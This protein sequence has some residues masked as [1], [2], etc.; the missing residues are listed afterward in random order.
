LQESN[1]IIDK[2]RYLSLLRHIKISA[3]KA[4]ISSK[5][6]SAYSRGIETQIEIIDD[7]YELSMSTI[8][9]CRIIGILMDNAIEAVDLCDKKNVQIAIVKND[10][11]IIFIINN[12][13]LEDTPPV[14]K[15]YEENFSTKGNGRGIGLKTVRHIINEKYDNVILNT[16]IKSCVF[17]QELIIHNLKA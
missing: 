11:S 16:K 13:C 5:I 3:L 14:Y 8:D 10:D 6:I 4:L 17:K 2:Y 7:I 15:V 12:S 9:I 1:K